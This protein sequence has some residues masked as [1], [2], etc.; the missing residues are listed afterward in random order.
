MGRCEKTKKHIL[1]DKLSL[2][3]GLQAG[4]APVMWERAVR[5]DLPEGRSDL[6]QPPGTN[7]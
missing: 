2:G 1:R 5:E 6:S 4:G 3:L 7:Q